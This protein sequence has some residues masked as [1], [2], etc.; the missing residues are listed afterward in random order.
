MLRDHSEAPFTDPSVYCE[1]GHIITKGGWK[2]LGNDR[3]LKGDDRRRVGHGVFKSVWI[4]GHRSIH[5]DL[6]HPIN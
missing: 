4:E 6:P 3:S 1:G 5:I 2:R